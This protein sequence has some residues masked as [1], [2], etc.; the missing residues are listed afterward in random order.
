MKERGN[1]L[2]GLLRV[3]QYQPNT[4]LSAQTKQ[5]FIG[6][7]AYWFPHPGRPATAALLV[8]FEQVTFEKFPATPANAKQQ[9]IAVHGL[10]NF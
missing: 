2:E 10:I 7:V 5:R 6:G 1:G 4:T 8:D 9:R 3:D